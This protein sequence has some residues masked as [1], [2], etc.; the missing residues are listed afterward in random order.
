MRQ[1]ILI[2]TALLFTLSCAKEEVPEPQIGSV[3]FG[4]KGE[5]SGDKFLLLAGV[6]G[7]FMLSDLFSPPDIPGTNN[8]GYYS[9]KLMN[10][11][12]DNG[13]E[14][15]EIKFE[16]I[17]SGPLNIT[18]LDDLL[19]RSTL[20]F[21]ND[22]VEELQYEVQFHADP[23]RAVKSYLWDFGDGNSSSLSN[24]IHNYTNTSPEKYNV[25]LTVIYDNDCSDMIC[26]DVFMLHA[27]CTTRMDITQV[28]DSARQIYTFTAI[29]GGTGIFSYLWEINNFLYVNGVETVEYSPTADPIDYIKL[30]V[31]DGNN[32][33][34]K[35]SRKLSVFGF[36]DLCM[37]NYHYDKPEMVVTGGNNP[38]PNV[39]IIYKDASGTTYS[40]Y[41]GI[42]NPG[43]F[44]NIIMH[45]SYKENERGQK[46]QKV[47]LEFSCD[48]YDLNGNAISLEN[49]RGRIAVARP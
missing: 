11:E 45:E 8:F 43:S 3:E 20:N 18:D 17:E 44:F 47:D 35:I 38:V 41:D 4:L 9:G 49:V 6:D 2:C 40:S 24:P 16:N 27:S 25:C 39:E 32:C 48:L 14:S 37:I 46:T 34:S 26:S 15:I 19:N 31:T 13:N 12:N 1:V 33:A 7:Y 28:I 21:K 10:L 5:L 23:E 36:N 42:Q 29:P 22:P 30:T